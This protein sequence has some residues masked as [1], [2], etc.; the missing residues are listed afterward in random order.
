M[1]KM[2]DLKDLLRHEIQDLYSAEEQ[3]IKAMPAMIEKARNPE[4][5]KSL[6]EHL[7][8]TEQQRNRLNQVQR[9]MGETSRET[10]ESGLFSRL[11]RR[12]QVCKGMEGILEEGEKI[13][14]EDMSPEV[15]D[16]AIIAAAQ[17]V[18]HYEIC[19]YGT[20]RAYAQELNLTEVANLLQQTLDE[21]YAADDLLTRLAV[22]RINE[23]AESTGRRTTTSGMTSERSRTGTGSREGARSTT[24]E[25]EM[26]SGIKGTQTPG[27]KGTTTGRSSVPTGSAARG[28]A[29]GRGTT[30]GRGTPTSSSRTTKTTAKGTGRNG[31][32]TGRGTTGTTR[33]RR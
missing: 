29:A 4:L 1:E 9:A 28:E 24:R 8:I 10:G 15:M 2:N 6:K 25:M 14:S 31:S 21:E 20:A 22:S 26:V 27:A 3:I 12:R 16:A 13:M 5:K 11:M 7:R 23:Q 17:K 18:E 32:T 30:T 19:G 33:G